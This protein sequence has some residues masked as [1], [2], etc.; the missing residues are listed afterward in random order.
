MEPDDPRH[1][2]A[3]GR[4]AHLVAGQEVCPPCAEANAIYQRRYRKN[5]A[6]YGDRLIPALGSSRRIQ[7]LMCLGWSTPAIASRAGIHP[8]Q[9]WWTTQQEHVTRAVAARIAAAY[10]A[11]H[12]ALPPTDTKSQRISV[13]VTRKN[14]ERNGFAP[15]LAW[16]D[17]DRDAKPVG[18]VRHG[19]FKD[20]VDE[21][22]I[23]RVLR[24]GERPRKLTKAEAREVYRR[25]LANGMTTYEIQTLYGLNLGRYTK[26]AA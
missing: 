1:G 19:G 10:E 8:K 13:A 26:D 11:M 25:A 18:K 24:G 20:S 6:L 17:I 12:M 14:A 4:R 2:T 21:A 15:P 5:R 16:D 23:D 22:M 9:V 7:A 3:R